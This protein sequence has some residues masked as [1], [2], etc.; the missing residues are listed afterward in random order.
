M[1]IYSIL[2][3]NLVATAPTVSGTSHIWKQTL[4]EKAYALYM[5]E[6][7]PSKFFRTQGLSLCLLKIG[8]PVHITKCVKDDK[9]NQATHKG[10]WLVQQK[11]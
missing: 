7:S 10:F 6:L 9:S 5:E 11:R 8:I 2:L 3:Y 1:A 4:I